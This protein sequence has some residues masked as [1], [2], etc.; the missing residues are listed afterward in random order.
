MLIEGGPALSV[1]AFIQDKARFQGQS[2]VLLLTGSKISLEQLKK[3]L[4]D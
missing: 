2:V 3:V 1:A 4:S